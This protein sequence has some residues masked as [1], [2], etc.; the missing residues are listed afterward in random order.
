MQQ[1]QQQVPSSRNR[2]IIKDEAGNISAGGGATHTHGPRRLKGRLEV[3]RELRLC[4][5]TPLNTAVA[6]QA[7][8]PG[9]FVSECT[10]LCCCIAAKGAA[11]EEWSVGRL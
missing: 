8:G 9:H 10:E 3:H 4:H 11:L 6:P 7:G 5:Q 2:G 1:Q